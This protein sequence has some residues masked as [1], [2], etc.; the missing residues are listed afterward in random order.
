MEILRCKGTEKRLYELVAPLVMSPAVLRQNNNYP[1]K[2]TRYH[3]WFLAVEDGE[4]VGFMP[5]KTG[6]GHPRI[7]NYYVRGDSDDTLDLL[8]ERVTSDRE[9]GG[10][11]TAMVHRRHADAFRRHGFSA[12]AESKNYE[13]MDY[14]DTREGAG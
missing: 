11:L 12:Y 8:L 14:D 2:T 9:L 7:D 3:V 13:R 5:V 10:S 1:F 4:I 6:E